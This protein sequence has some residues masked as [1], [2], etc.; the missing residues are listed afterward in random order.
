MKK[1]LL[2]FLATTLLISCSDDEGNTQAPDYV[3]A[4]IN[5]IEYNFTVFD[6]DKQTYTD[7][8]Y[9]YTDVI[10]DAALSNDSTRHIR[11]VVEQGITGPDASWMFAY[12]VNNV[13]HM[14]D[15]NFTF[16]VSEST[17]KFVKGTFAGRVVNVDT[18]DEFTVTDGT[19]SVNH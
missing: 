10:I 19:F 15:E 3:R 11:F 1:L 18:G 17:E 6:L 13:P 5:G 4:K 12:Y 2:F 14:K 8:G 7:N 16:V 9:T